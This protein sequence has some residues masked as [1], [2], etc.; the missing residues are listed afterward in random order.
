MAELAVHG[1]SPVRTGPYP[2]WPIGGA[3]ER[4][5]L[6][7]VLTSRR[8]FAG[9]QADDPDAAGTLFGRRFADLHGAG[10][11]LPVANGS[12]AIEIALRALGIEPGDEVIVPCYTFIST[13]TSVLIVG[14]IPVFADIDP[15]SYCLD[16][17]DAARRITPRT[18]AIVPVH[19]GGHMADM[20]ALLNIARRRG[21]HVLEDCAQAIDA[22]LSGQK[23]GTWGDVGTFSFQSNKTMT[24]GEGGLIMTDSPGLAERITALR[25]F[26][27]FNTGDAARSSALECR[28]LSSNYRLSEFQSAVLLGQLDAFPA[29]DARRQANAARLTG[30]VNRLPGLRHVR[31]LGAD[32]KHGYYYYLVRYD[33]QHFRQVSPDRLCQILSAE[34]VPFVPGDRRPVYRHLVFQP[35]NVR[36]HLQPEA[37]ARY[38]DRFANDPP[39]CPAAEAACDCTI[40]LR[41]QVLLAA[42]TDIDDIGEALS[43]VATH[44]EEILEEKQ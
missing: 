41:H 24:S 8:W 30:H 19:L 11:G 17:A 9:L 5:Q 42:P 16:P 21:L 12:V 27:R 20:P 36:S 39:Q 7:R 1:G 4:A 32:M 13:A 23:A 25:A 43:K 37:F 15:G 18:R 31:T 44:V 29:Q 34:G 40:M 26:G 2:S 35:D 38:K 10:H 3:E 22:T 6:E 28:Q 14:A 33:P